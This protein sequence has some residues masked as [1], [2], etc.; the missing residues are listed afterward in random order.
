MSFYTT[1]QWTLS[2]GPGTGKTTVLTA[3]VKILLEQLKDS[4]QGV[5]V[6]T[7]TNIAVDEIK[8]SLRKLGIEDIKILTLLELFKIFSI[9]F[10]LRKRFI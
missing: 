4:G 2:F 9:H 1:I 3:R 7:H 5:C 8:S 10:L 6:L